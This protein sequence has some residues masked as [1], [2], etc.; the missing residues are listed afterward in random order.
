[1][2]W[3]D[4]PVLAESE[5]WP[6]IAPLSKASEYGPLA[7]DE[8]LVE[9]LPEATAVTGLQ[10]PSESIANSVVAAYDDAIEPSSVSEPL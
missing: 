6:S 10:F 7:V 3:Y 1:M 2:Y 5:N 8:S 9:P 4:E